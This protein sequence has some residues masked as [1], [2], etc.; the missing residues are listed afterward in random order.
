MNNKL[1]II[2]WNDDNHAE[3]V[4]INGEYVGDMNDP[5]R[6]FKALMNIIQDE[7]YP[8][9]DYEGTCIWGCDAFDEYSDLFANEDE[10]ED[11]VEEMWDWFN[12]V[13]KMTPEQVELIEQLKLDKL[14]KETIM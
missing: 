2:R 12:T 9:T 1:S 6:I 13:E 7:H 5:D 10:F 4:W 11:W 8:F 3:R 14:Y